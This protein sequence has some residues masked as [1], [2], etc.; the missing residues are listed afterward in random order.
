[1]ITNMKQKIS[2]INWLKCTIALAALLIVSTANALGA[3]TYSITKATMVNGSVSM[4]VGG[5]VASEAAA[6]ATVTIT[7]S[8]STGYEADGTPVVNV[9]T[10]WGQANTRAEI[11]ME[12]EI[13][14][15]AGTT[16]NTWTFTMPNDDV[17]VSMA[18]K[19]STYAITVSTVDGGTLGAKKGTEA[20]T[21]AQIGDEITLSNTPSTGWEFVSYSVKDAAENAVTVTNGKFTMPA[22]NVTVS[23][24]FKKSTY[25]I[26]IAEGITNGTVTASAATATMGEEITVTIT[27]AEGY[28]LKTLSVKSGETDIAVTN[29]KFTMPIGNVTVSAEFAKTDYTVTIAEGIQNGT[30]TASAFGGNIGD[31]ITLTATPAEGYELDA[32]SVKD[33]AGNAVAVTNGKFTM[34][35]SNV[36]V[37]ATFKKSTY[38]ITIAEGITNGTVTASAAT[39]TMGEEITLTA[40]P[41]EG[42]NLKTLSV[43]SGETD[44]AVTNGKFTMPAGDV[45]VSAEF[46]KTAYTITVAG[47]IQNGTVTASALSGNMGDEITLTATPADGYELDAYSVKDAAGNAVAVTNGKITMPAS[48]VTVS[49]TFKKT[50]YTI[51]IAEGITNG[52]VTASAATATM[53][54]EIT[55][56]ITPAEGY[57]L[58]TLSVKSGETDITVTNGKFTM[59]AGDVTVSAEFSKTAYTVTIAEGIQNGT[60]T[61]SALSGNMGDKITLTATPATGYELEAFSVKDAAGN[62]VAVT[63]GKFTMP[64]SNVTVSATFKETPLKLVDENKPVKTEGGL[65]LYE[66]TDDCKEVLKIDD[67]VGIA[68]SKNANTQGRADIEGH[69]VLATGPIDVSMLVMDAPAGSQVVFVCDGSIFCESNNIAKAPRIAT[70]TRGS[71]SSMEVESGAIYT[72][73]NDDDILLTLKTSVAEV[74]IISITVSTAATVENSVVIAKTTNGDISS[75]KINAQAGEQVNLKVTPDE[76]YQLA[77]LSVKD[78][79]GKPLYVGYIVDPKEGP[80]YYFLMPASN[81]IVNG[82]FEEDLNLS[83][84]VAKSEN[85]EVISSM[86]NSRQGKQVN[87]KAIPDD[88]YELDELKVID[89]EGKSIPLT[90][91]ENTEEGPINFFIMPET[92]VTVYATFKKI[93]PDT[94]E[95]LYPTITTQ[96]EDV[97]YTIGDAEY[98]K[99]SVEATASA[100]DLTYEW[101]VKNEDGNYYSSGITTAELDLKAFINN[102]I[103]KLREE[104][105]GDYTF[106]CKVTD[107][108]GTVESDPAILTIAGDPT[109]ANGIKADAQAVRIRKYVK[110]GKLVIETPNGIFT[111]SGVQI[112]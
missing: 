86:V 12:S 69:L 89:A 28:N 53:G 104:A 109:A 110:N 36:T 56:T 15:K 98:P 52:T 49:A 47:D 82:S 3:E 71:N 94:P 102:M 27:P 5:A 92:N 22:S 84:I 31:E 80:F 88:G 76:G 62:A 40:T 108:N 50:T 60:V 55:L 61:A 73:T 81:V 46:T 34:P 68:L 21:T 30:V 38:T 45:T 100:G 107:D 39:A 79:N 43:K 65:T 42:Y 44:I 66:L 51:T 25:T 18:F 67:Y 17:T 103:E 13:A 95:I 41:A 58:K 106:M 1:M 29:G 7:A 4:T 9:T 105:I 19:K 35:A 90:F 54:E 59:P 33:A 24:T 70:R 87:L 23:A 74:K 16:A 99:M 63:N 2:I 64:A 72:K 78:E 83:V 97:T 10:S 26:T 85:G 32:Y 96:P 57:N 75:S 14:V 11:P 112:K 37:S 111:V 48:N 6:G 93:K 8:P 77:S 20:A 91:V 101:F